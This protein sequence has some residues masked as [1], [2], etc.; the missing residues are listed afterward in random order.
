MAHTD[1]PGDLD[2]SVRER[3][4]SRDPDALDR[5]FDRHFSEI[6]QIVARAVQSEHTAEDLTQEVFVKVYESLPTYDPERPLGPWLHA[7]A[8][9][10]VR[11]HWRSLGRPDAA[12]PSLDGDERPRLLDEGAIGPLESI[13]RDEF[14]DELDRAVRRLPR[15]LRRTVE[16]RVFA[17]LSFEDVARRLDRTTIAVRKRYSRALGMLRRDL[18]EPRW[19]G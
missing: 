19:V 13:E 11:D 6:H 3:L 1:D 9:N 15:G 7:I 5:L 4:A 14:E 2:R 18:D 12:G 8:R 17:G 16:M 10:R